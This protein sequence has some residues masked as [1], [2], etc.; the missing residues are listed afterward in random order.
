LV[1]GGQIGCPERDIAEA[2]MQR[3]RGHEAHIRRRH[4]GHGVIADFIAVDEKRFLIQEYDA[5]VGRYERP[6]TDLFT[7]VHG[8]SVTAVDDALELLV[9]VNDKRKD[10]SIRSACG[11]RKPFRICS[12]LK[13]AVRP[14]LSTGWRNI[15]VTLRL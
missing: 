7:F 6:A 12:R 11:R 10:A 14:L 4:C 8:V 5:P 2:S 3:Y 1:G 9:E 15:C 13:V